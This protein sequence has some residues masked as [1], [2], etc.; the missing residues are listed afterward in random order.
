M[1]GSTKQR[2]RFLLAVIGCIPVALA[3]LLLG[4]SLE[5]GSGPT[6][7]GKTAHQWTR[8]LAR[9]DANP[10][11]VFKALKHLG[12]DTAGKHLLAALDS[13]PYTASTRYDRL[14]RM[15]PGW[16]NRRMPTPVRAEVW[17]HNVM[18][19]LP[20]LDPVSRTNAATKLVA[21]LGSTNEFTR[22]KSMAVLSGL[23]IQKPE[24][25]RALLDVVERGPQ[26]EALTAA[27]AL[28]KLDPTNAAL[29]SVLLR[30]LRSDKA[31]VK[32]R[33]VEMLGHMG[34]VAEQALPAL[35]GMLNETDEALSNAAEDA[36]RQIER[37]LK[38]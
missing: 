4:G 10:I 25:T 26:N 24:V 32:L 6:Y 9:E 36:A 28:H 19:L 3:M 8:Q 7:Q 23:G 38:H 33:T 21:F 18:E 12:P 22:L 14:W 20:E 1:L 5:W 15:M 2:K 31:Y 11:D 35:R 27:F 34:V 16:V 17:R 37:E 29:V 13:P 30:W